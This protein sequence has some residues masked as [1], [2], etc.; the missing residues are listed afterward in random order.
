MP[1]A[2]LIDS[3][4]WVHALRESGNEVVRQR[5]ARLMDL[6]EATWCEAIRL[7][8]WNGARGH[9]EQSRLKDFDA[10][11]PRLPID[12]PT[13]E[14]ACSIARKARQAGL[15][16]PAIDLL[17]F[18]CARRHGAAIEHSDEHFKHLEKL[19][20]PAPEEN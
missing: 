6:G 5:V 14:L 13:W 12:E 19:A 20:T 9:A 3:S 17:I 10:E 11:L 7:E 15:T 2:T 4:S 16:I 18:A 1:T 8:L